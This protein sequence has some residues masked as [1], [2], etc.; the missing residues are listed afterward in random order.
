M[1]VLLAIAALTGVVSLADVSPCALLRSAL[2]QAKC[3][4][5]ARNS[6][7]VQPSACIIFHKYMVPQHAALFTVKLKQ[8][9]AAELSHVHMCACLTALIPAHLSHDVQ[10]CTK[11]EQLH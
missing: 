10:R 2:Q 11:T 1:E 7:R 5:T 9:L 4:L 6:E 8:C 3:M